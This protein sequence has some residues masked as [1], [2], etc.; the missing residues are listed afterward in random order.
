M[1]ACCGV[2]GRTSGS[3]DDQFTPAK[4]GLQQEGHSNE[5]N[6]RRARTGR[7]RSA[8]LTNNPVT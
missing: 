3:S 4:K 1:E 6:R 7:R 2:P 8:K 5:V